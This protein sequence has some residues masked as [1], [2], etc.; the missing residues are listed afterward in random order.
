MDK[1]KY[2][3]KFEEIVKLEETLIDYGFRAW[4][5]GRIVIDGTSTRCGYMNEEGVSISYQPHDEDKKSKDKL[6][7][8]CK[9]HKFPYQKGEVQYPGGHT[10]WEAWSK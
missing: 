6:V 9:T 8:L 4:D 10:K 7:S 1:E 2:I 3:M 5:D